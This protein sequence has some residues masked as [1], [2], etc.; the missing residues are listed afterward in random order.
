[1]GYRSIKRNWWLWGHQPAGCQFA[2]TSIDR[3]GD[4]TENGRTATVLG[5]TA[6][7]SIKGVASMKLPPFLL[8]KILVFSVIPLE[9]ITGYRIVVVRKAGGL[10]VAVRFCLPRRIV[11]M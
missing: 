5:R 1:M 2:E 9:K 10:V 3:G 11:S 6:R 7:S 8:Q 4:P